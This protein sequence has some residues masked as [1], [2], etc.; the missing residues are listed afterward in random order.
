MAVLAWLKV[1]NCWEPDEATGLSGAD[2][3][4]FM[5]ASKYELQWV[6]RLLFEGRQG[7]AVLNYL[8]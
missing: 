1:L 3:M 8:N 6:L 2:G 5:L 4:P 7:P